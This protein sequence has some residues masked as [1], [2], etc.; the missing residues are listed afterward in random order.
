M[1]YFSYQIEHITAR[2][3][4][5]IPENLPCYRK[6]RDQAHVE[7]NFNHTIRIYDSYGGAT[8]QHEHIFHWHDFYEEKQDILDIRTYTA[9]LFE[10]LYFVRGAAKAI[11]MHED[12][13]GLLS[14]RYD[15]LIT[16]L[17]KTDWPEAQQ[18]I[19][20]AWPILRPQ[21]VYT[22]IKYGMTE[23]IVKGTMIEWAEI[24]LDKNEMEA[25][26]FIYAIMKEKYWH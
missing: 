20:D 1:G 6:L 22:R 15:A 8:R 24:L 23:M 4:Y 12:C 3:H 25:P 18:K 2:F 21:S 9:A 17:V 16:D 13:I 26:E 7:I 5:N 11:E 19:L 10:A 14:P